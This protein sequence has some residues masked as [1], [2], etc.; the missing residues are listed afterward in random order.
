MGNQTFV[1]GVDG[2]REA[3]RM[4]AFASGADASGTDASGTEP[5]VAN[6]SGATA[7][8]GAAEV[9]EQQHRAGCTAAYS[10]TYGRWEGS[11]RAAESAQ[12]G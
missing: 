8:T 7:G 1:Y 5:G 2:P 12:A 4:R 10:V 6:S 3:S 9:N 11:R